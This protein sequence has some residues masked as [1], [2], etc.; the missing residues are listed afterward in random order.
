MVCLLFLL[1]YFLLIMCNVQETR[2]IGSLCGS[3]S[4]P[5]FLNELVPL[6]MLHTIHTWKNFLTLDLVVGSLTMDFK[7]FDILVD[8]FSLELILEPAIN[9]ALGRFNKSRVVESWLT[10][11]TAILVFP[12]NFKLHCCS[13]YKL[14]GLSFMRRSRRPSLHLLC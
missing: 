4:S 6:T 2:M 7:I 11:S 3:I 8:I 10:I 1:K 5:P 13:E 12:W 9:S 14:L